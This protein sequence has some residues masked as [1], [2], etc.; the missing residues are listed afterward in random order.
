MS[1]EKQDVTC[2]MCRAIINTFLDYRRIEKYD[3][4][5]LL[6]EAVDLCLSMNLQPESTCEAIIQMHI[7]P[8]VYIIDQNPKLEANHICSMILQTSNCGSTNINYSVKIEEKSKESQKN[9]ENQISDETSYRVLHITDIHFDPRYKPGSN[10]QCDEP[11]CCRS[12]EPD[13]PEDAAG[14]YGDYRSCDVPWHSVVNAMSHINETHKDLDWIYFTGDLVD[15]GIWETSVENNVEIMEKVFQLLRETFPETPLFPILGNHETHPV[16]I[17]APNH[18][19]DNELSTNW[20]F[21]YISEAWLHWLPNSTLSTIKK[22]GFYT[23]L[24]KPK[25]RV[26]ALNNNDCYIYNWWTLYSTDAQLEQLQWF[27][28]TLFEAEKN[29]EKVHVL[30][31]IYPGEGSCFVVWSREYKRIIERFHETIRAQ[32]YGHSHYD[33]FNI[34]YENQNPQKPINVGWNGGSLTPFNDIN[35]NYLIYNVS[36]I[37][38]DVLDYESWS[39]NL[40]KANENIEKGPEWFKLYS[41]KDQFN[42]ENTNLTSLNDLVHQFAADRKLLSKFWELKMKRGDPTLRRGCDEKCLKAT[43]CDIVKNEIGDK[44]ILV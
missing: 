37:S 8:L 40:T 34:F 7:P 13:S 39:Y 23:T 19:S 21:N 22:G 24:I 32:F 20:L 38:F 3:E 44:K 31:H 36:K 29:N 6:E 26:I 16:N 14:F 2:L 35:P 17:F 42:L 27:H 28:D 10:A 33:E 9:E 15:H 1:E 4:E 12:G 11:T 18:I 43:I 5:Q 30:A 25:L 41:F